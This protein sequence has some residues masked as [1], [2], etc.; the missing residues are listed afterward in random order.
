LGKRDL[1]LGDLKEV[2]LYRCF[3]TEDGDQ[4]GDFAFGIVD[5]GNSTKK[6]SERSFND[7]DGLTHGESS[8]EFGSGLLTESGDSLDFIFWKRSGL[9]G[10][11][12]KTGDA[13]CGANSEPGVV[14]DNH[15][16]K[17]VARK[18]LFFDSGFLAF[19]DFN[20]FLGRDE[21]LVDIVLE[22]HG[23]D[24]GFKG[25]QNTIFVTGLGVNDVPFGGVGGIVGND[26]MI[27]ILHFGY[28]F[29]DLFGFFFF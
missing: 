24:S 3:A 23:D 20:F 10:S 8:L 1:N 17:H 4:N 25:N 9:V 28:K 16:D 27:R 12:H 6:I 18:K 19:V 13:L 26:N 29:V 21:D 7:S 14:R 11:A 5:G 15:A 22:G 2:E